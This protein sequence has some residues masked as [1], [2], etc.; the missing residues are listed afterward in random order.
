MVL[1]A[2]TAMQ[3][4][5]GKDLPLAMQ[6][7]QLGAS[8]AA[9][10]GWLREGAIT[11]DWWQMP[12]EGETTACELSRCARFGVASRAETVWIPAGAGADGQLTVR[13]LNGEAL[14]L[15][16]A[17]KFERTFSC[18]HHVSGSTFPTPNLLRFCHVMK[19]PPLNPI[20]S[21]PIP[22]SLLIGTTASLSPLV[23]V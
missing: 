3:G 9:A 5:S 17:P 12:Q 22:I 6:P 16:E 8:A 23:L 19:P 15:N 14:V 21:L 2:V 13:G 7:W 10:S 18:Q 4:G 1:R 11:S 20:L